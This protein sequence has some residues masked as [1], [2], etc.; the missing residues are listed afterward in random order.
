MNFNALCDSNKSENII[1][2]L[3]LAASGG[4]IIYFV[5][6]PENEQI[7]FAVNSYIIIDGIGYIVVVAFAR[8]VVAVA[9]A[10]GGEQFDFSAHK[11]QIAQFIQIK[12]L[13][14]DIIKKRLRIALFKIIHQFVHQLLRI[15]QFQSTQFTLKSFFTVLRLLPDRFFEIRAYALSGA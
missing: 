2:G 7:H 6:A 5:Q 14:G 13:G 10:V 3:R 9:F 12:L 11:R 1:A 4:G 8:C 15:L